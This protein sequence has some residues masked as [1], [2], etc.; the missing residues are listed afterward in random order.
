MYWNNGKPK[1]M[2]LYDRAERIRWMIW[3]RAQKLCREAGVSDAGCLHNALVGLHNGRPWREVD[4]SKAR[5][6]K[7]LFD[8]Q[9]EAKNIVDRYV[10]RVGHRNLDWAR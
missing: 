6:A 2:P 5:L 1:V 8:K 10:D 9:F 7:R 4:Y 3:N